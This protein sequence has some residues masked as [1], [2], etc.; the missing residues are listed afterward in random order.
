VPS[1]TMTQENTSQA[2]PSPGISKLENSLDE[3]FF[4]ASE[5]VR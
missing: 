5:V 2:I 1:N 3:N 4:P